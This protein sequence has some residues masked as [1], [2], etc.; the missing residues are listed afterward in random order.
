[1]KDFLQ[2]NTLI[3]CLILIAF[4]CS[5]GEKKEIIG[6]FPAEYLPDY[7]TPLTSY[8]Q[9]AEWSL[10]GT[11]VYFVDRA[12][13]DVFYVDIETKKITQVTD[14]TT[15]PKGYGYYRVFALSDGDMLFTCGPKRHDAYGQIMKKGSGKIHSLNEKI[16]EG[17][18][19]S[20]TDMKIVWTPDQQVIYSGMIV[21]NE[22]SSTIINKTLLI[23]NDSVVVDG[24]RYDGILESQ[25]FIPPEEKEFT[26]T[27]YGNTSSGLFT[28][29][30]MTYNLETG[31]IT[32]HSKSPNEYSEPEGVFPDGKYTLIECDAH[33]HKG[34]NYIDIYKM[35]LDGSG[36]ISARLTRFNDIE[37]YKGSNPVVRDDGKMIAFQ[38]ANAQAA[39][40][41]GCGLYLMDLEKWEQSNSD[42]QK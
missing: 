42:A 33:C 26:W 14:S 3:F 30:V 40:G 1:M 11:R 24:I 2:V 22:D 13:G 39:A 18:T 7:I 4:S 21:T 41:V 8:G 31:E 15:R 16:D 34:I 20:R 25:N 38:A 9:R 23:D 10:D 28:S 35:K 32:N 29:E 37:G 27:Q 17:P 5:F 12:G 36:E 19:I 6:C